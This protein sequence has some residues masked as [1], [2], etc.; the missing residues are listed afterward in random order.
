MDV[1]QF[2]KTFV[3]AFIVLIVFDFIWLFL[4]MGGFYK[5]QFG[6]IMRLNG[7]WYLSYLPAILAW[8]VIALGVVVFVLPKASSFLSAWGFGA[9]FGFVTY[10]IYN[11]TNLATITQWSWLLLVADTAWGTFV[12]GL[13]SL[14]VYWINGFW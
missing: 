11:F 10:G 14:V 13:V 6:Q 5:R 7:E 2:I 1:I 9:L 8:L 3:L 12:C 4:I